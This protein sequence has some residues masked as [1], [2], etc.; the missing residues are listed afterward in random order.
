MAPQ[1][2]FSFQLTEEDVAL[3]CD[4]FSVRW[5]RCLLPGLVISAVGVFVAIALVV[6]QPDWL[7]MEF[8]NWLG[9]DFAVIAAS[10]VIAAS[11]KLIP[12]LRRSLAIRQFRRTPTV[13]NAMTY[14]IFDDHVTV[15]SELGKGQIR[16]EGFLKAE[17]KP[18]HLILYTSP[19]VGYIIP[20]AYLTATDASQLREMVRERITGPPPSR[21]FWRRWF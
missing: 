14:Q 20:L 11:G 9:L 1:I 17:E 15:T 16:W 19:I 10:L 5:R 8:S 6:L 12:K 3:N 2:E 13:Q 18:Q 21:S 4:A 7:G